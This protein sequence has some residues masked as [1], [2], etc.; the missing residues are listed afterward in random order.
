[1]H[2]E[3]SPPFKVCSY[4]RMPLMRVLTRFLLVSWFIFPTLLAADPCVCKQELVGTREIIAEGAQRFWRPSLAV[5]SLT[6]DYVIAWLQEDQGAIRSILVQIR[7]S[8][9]R[10]IA[11]IALDIGNLRDAPN[12]PGLDAHVAFNSIR[13]EFLVAWQ[14]ETPSLVSH[15]PEADVY[16]LSWIVT[17]GSNTEVRAQPFSAE[18]VALL[19][20]RRIESDS[21]FF[22]SGLE[23]L[24]SGFQHRFV[25]FW[26][27]DVLKA[28]KILPSLSVGKIRSLSP[29]DAILDLD[30]Q[31]NPLTR[32][33]LLTSAIENE[34][35]RFTHLNPDF[36][37]LKENIAVTCQATV[38]STVTVFNP[39]TK[40]FL[41]VWN[42]ESGSGSA[43]L[44]RRI[45]AV[46][47]PES[48]IP[49]S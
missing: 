10:Q 48:C 47:R 16:L 36:S 4:G 17:T 22:L 37:P 46:P 39:V 23:L 7:S 8:A 34:G 14:R 5:N 15:D 40:E 13:N 45:H 29:A 1:M 30:I 38:S 11:Q 42:K 49:G 24:F 9:N 26:S 2:V 28:R 18:L 3:S 19:A 35:I 41:I 20:S 43:I 21:V 25:A 27:A 32:G 6:G 12:L 33:F 44:S 31:F